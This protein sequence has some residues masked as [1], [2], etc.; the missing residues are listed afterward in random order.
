MVYVVCVCVLEV[1]VFCKQH[2]RRLDV[3]QF[4]N[5]GCK[6]D[7]LEKFIIVSYL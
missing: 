1:N 6:A 2:Y 4:T 5:V 3:G 7:M